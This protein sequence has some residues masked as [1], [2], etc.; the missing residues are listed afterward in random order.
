MRKRRPTTHEENLA[1]LA[2]V[3]G[4]IRGIRRMIE[5]GAYCMDILNQIQAVRAAL[6]AV[7][8]RVLRKHLEVCVAAAARSR[9]RAATEEKVDEVMRLLRGDG[10]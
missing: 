3:E 7:G 5:G 1:R 4:Q 10:E 2:R 9:S 6:R 8:H